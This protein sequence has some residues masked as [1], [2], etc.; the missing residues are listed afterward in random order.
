MVVTPLL[1]LSTLAFITIITQVVK[2]AKA[3][4]AET[5]R[6][7]SDVSNGTQEYGS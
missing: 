4:P 3:N 1:I 5:L 7:S 6:P 2:A